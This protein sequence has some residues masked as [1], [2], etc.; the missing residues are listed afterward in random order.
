MYFGEI[1]EKL[2]IVF[3]TEE[4]PDVFSNMVLEFTGTLSNSWAVLSKKQ[5]YVHDS[6]LFKPQNHIDIF[7]HFSSNCF[8]N[9]K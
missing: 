2:I 8:N 5:R 6:A 3:F 7:P 4:T 9:G 1:A